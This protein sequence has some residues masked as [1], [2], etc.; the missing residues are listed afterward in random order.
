LTA[1]RANTDSESRYLSKK[2]AWDGP[3]VS[4]A[5]LVS[6]YPAL[7]MAWLLREILQLRRMGFRVDVASVNAPDYDLDKMNSSE[8]A[9]AGAAYRLKRHGIIGAAKA[10][11]LTL[12]QHPAG[13]LRGLALLLRLGH[14]DLRSLFFNFMYFTE[15]MMVG[16]WMKRKRHHHLHVHLASQG[17]TVGLYTQRVFGC[18][19][20]ITVHGPDEFYDTKGQYLSQKIAS[21]DFI[22]CISSFARSQLM[23]LSP[24]EDWG[25]LLVSRLGVDAEVFAPRPHRPFPAPLEIMCVGRLTPS[26][27]QHLLI[28]AVEQLLAKG[29]NVRLRL[30]GDGPDMPSLRRQAAETHS[31]GAFLFEGAVTQSRIREFYARTDIFCMAS[32]AEG[33]PVVLMEAMAMEIPCVA[34]CITGIPELIR[35]RVEGLLVP[36]SD[37]IGL[38]AAL[39][40]LIDN[41]ELRERLGRAGRYRV[42][43]CYDLTSNTKALAEIFAAN[44][45]PL[46][47]A[48]SASR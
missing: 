28:S 17:A 22:C 9:E 8:A 30:V 4:L 2:E 7:S 24:I 21:A 23:R 20:S 41:P 27:G 43:E 10:H 33:I 34:T 15:G 29:R 47:K 35:D 16:V 48:S 42:M 1:G 6:T 19:F 13:Y 25:K 37:V 31:P 36:A 46:A 38:A 5:Y 12:L 11:L 44:V 39:S 18:G 26:K 14:T 40:E 32:F 3:N 45:K